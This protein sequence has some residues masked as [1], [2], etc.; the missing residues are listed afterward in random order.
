[1][2]PLLL[3]NSSAR[4]ARSVTRH[5]TA[6]FA[7]AWTA[8]HPKAE[9]LWRDV[10]L[11]PPPFINESWI[12]AAFADARKQTPTMRESLATS[13]A[14][15]EELHSASVVVIGA[16]MYNF[17]MP[18]G[19][20]AYVDQIVRLGRTFAMGGSDDA[21]PYQPL[22]P[23]KPLVLITSAGA[24]GYEPGGPA[25]HLNFLEPHLEAVFRFIGFTDVSFVRVG[26]EEH[27][28]ERFRKLLADAERAVDEIVARLSPDIPECVPV[29]L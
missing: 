22:V 1:M 8:R 18:A 17:G 16:P 4:A 23:A 9:I 27:Q 20:K 5:L 29:A 11:N 24:A 15:I 3:V 25:A 21:W 28:G 19:L 7:S 10:G 26:S 13:E 6:R 14:L 12:A 2:K